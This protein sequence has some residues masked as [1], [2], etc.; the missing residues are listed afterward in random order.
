MAIENVVEVTWAL[1]ILKIKT[2]KMNLKIWY[3]F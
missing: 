2:I 1:A 3:C